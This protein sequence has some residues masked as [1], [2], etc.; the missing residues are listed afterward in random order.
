M[1]K[2]DASESSVATLW[3]SSS[4]GRGKGKDS[5]LTDAAAAANLFRRGRVWIYMMLFIAISYTIYT[6][7]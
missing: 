4:E 1:C 2:E 7:I 6:I 3:S 5:P